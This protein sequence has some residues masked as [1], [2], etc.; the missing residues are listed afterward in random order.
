MLESTHLKKVVKWPHRYPGRSS[1]G[2]KKG[3]GKFLQWEHAW[4]VRGLVKAHR[5]W[6]EGMRTT[7]CFN[8]MIEMRLHRKNKSILIVLGSGK[9]SMQVVCCLASAQSLL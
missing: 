9:Y 5:E 6:E 2:G 7:C 3:N 8:K 4:H 1:T